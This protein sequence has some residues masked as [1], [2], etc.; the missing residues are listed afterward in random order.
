MDHLIIVFDFM[1]H[2]SLFAKQIKCA[3][4]TDK[5]EYLGHYIEAKGIFTDPKKV[6]VD[7]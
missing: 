5:V 2:N 6:T 1:R 4:A 7:E 3:F